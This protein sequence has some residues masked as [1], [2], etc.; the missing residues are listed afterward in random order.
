[1]PLSVSITT[2]SY[3]QGSFISDAVLSVQ[4][5]DYPHVEQ[6]VIDGGSADETC[7]V[8]REMKRAY[9]DRLHW[10]S[11]SDDGQSDAINK[12][13]E[14]TTGDIVAWLNADDMYYPG[15]ISR[16]VEVF[17]SDPAIDVVYG[18]G[19]FLNRDGAFLTEFP[20]IGRA[21]V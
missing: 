21:H 3:G 9:P 20:Q 16:V 4:E 11:E 10:V 7:D 1:M 19:V 14:R 18:K 2:P 15:V 8:L 12:G 5:Q 13:F 17:E 6:W